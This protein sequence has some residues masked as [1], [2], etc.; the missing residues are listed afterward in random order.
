MFIKSTVYICRDI[1]N[2]TRITIDKA[3]WKESKTFDF[4]ILKQRL[5]YVLRRET[6]NHYF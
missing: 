2:I 6:N 5:Y 4:H 3:E 1:K